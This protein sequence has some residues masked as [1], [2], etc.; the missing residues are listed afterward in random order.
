MLTAERAR[1]VF[2]YNPETGSLAWR[3]QV[4]SRRSGSVAGNIQTKGYLR[5]CVDGRY[6]LLHRVA[7][8][9]THGEWPQDQIDHINGDR[10]DNRIANLRL[11]TA[12]QNCGNTGTS[13]N[14][15]SGFK[16]VS[17]SARARR[18]VSSIRVAG[19][20]HWL[21]YFPSRE[22][23]AEAYAAADVRLRGAFSASLRYQRR[24]HSTDRGL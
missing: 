5:L 1:E 3:K 17:W 16:G 15:T 12:S 23:A 2:E 9:I 13:K 19:R 14:N 22:A 7:W 18:W 24:P 10:L 21:G 6:Y 4:G 11:A 8:L 20:R